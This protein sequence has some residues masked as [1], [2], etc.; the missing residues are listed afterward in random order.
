MRSPFRQAYPGSLNE[1]IDVQSR[2]HYRLPYRL[3][4]PVWPRLSK[5]ATA[6]LPVLGKFMNKDT[7]EAFP[8]IKT[9]CKF[10]G[11]SAHKVIEGIRCLIYY[12]LVEKRKTGG[13][14]GH[15][16]YKLKGKAVYRSTETYLL[17]TEKMLDHWA[18]LKP[19]EQRVYVILLMKATINEGDEDFGQRAYG[20][21]KV[22]KLRDLTGIT[23]P[24]VYSAVWGLWKKSWI[25]FD[26]IDESFEGSGKIYYFITTNYL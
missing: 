10:S 12:D 11:Y 15:N 2:S 26:D 19:C 3:I 7:R 22:E 20:E 16:V 25:D 9:L 17:F 6:V 23:R 18:E 5:P 24:S 4:N 8:S 14:K 13:I 21:I 1:V